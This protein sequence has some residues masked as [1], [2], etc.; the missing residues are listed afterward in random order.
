MSDTPT[1]ESDL[2]EQA[3]IWNAAFIDAVRVMR[4]AQR[5]FSNSKPVKL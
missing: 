4:A 5:A 2:A 1:F 3:R